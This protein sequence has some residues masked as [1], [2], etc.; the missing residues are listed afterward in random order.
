[1]SPRPSRSQQLWQACETNLFVHF[2]LNTFASRE[3]GEGL[4]SPSIFN[5]VKLDCGQ[6]AKTAREAGMKIGILTAKHHDGFCLW[7]TQTTGYSVKSA[8]WRD[9][10]GDLVREFVDAFRSEGLKVGL[11]LSPWDRHEPCYGDS[12]RYNDFYC[13]QLTE[14]LTRYGELHEV[15]FDGACAEGPDGRKQVYD[16]PRF[17]S[18]VKELQPGAVTFGDGGTD[19]RWVGNER[20]FADET[21]WS[22]V[23]PRTVRFPGDSGI[24]QANDA[25][26][27]EE[28]TRHF[29]NGDA[30]GPG[31]DEPRV[32]RPAECDVSIRP[33]WFYHADEDDQ[34]RTPENLFDLYLKSVGRNSLLLLNVP[35]T[36]EGLF[37][38]AD[39]AS[40]LAFRRHLDATFGNDLAAGGAVNADTEAPGHAASSVLDG[41]PG[42]FWAAREGQTGGVLE[43]VFPRAATVGFLCLQE[44]V[45]MGQRI[46]GWRA[47][48][49]LPGGDWRE[50][51]SGTTVGFKRIVRIGAIPT[52]SIRITLKAFSAP[53]LTGISVFAPEDA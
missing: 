15:W 6:W 37:H 48:A 31:T 11:Y 21:C 53:A 25:A 40:L 44:A 7:P 34:V 36:P 24:A 35:P 47:E 22:T 49:R 5:P 50:V 8:P 23:D 1:M 38:E 10:K 46:H 29:S 26:A 13:A 41:D 20:G 17:F 12:P 43:I 33:G 39:I 4:D 52:D 18:L 19:V 32:W 16:W 2:G 27:R 28:L 45:E 14:L 51:A 3:W 9:G 30:P 42:T